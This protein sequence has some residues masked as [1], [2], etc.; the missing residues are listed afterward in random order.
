MGNRFESARVR[1]QFRQWWILSTKATRKAVTHLSGNFLTLPKQNK[2]KTEQKKM[3]KAIAP[4]NASNLQMKTAVGRVNPAKAT[5]P[6][7]PRQS[8]G[9][10]MNHCTCFFLLATPRRWCCCS[11]WC[12]ALISPSRASCSPCWRPSSPPGSRWSSPPGTAGR[13]C[14]KRPESAP[15]PARSS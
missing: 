15:A 13:P 5:P 10:W 6:V 3:A 4:S 14:S 2:V 1:Y 9:I 12:P 8:A 7:G 11:A